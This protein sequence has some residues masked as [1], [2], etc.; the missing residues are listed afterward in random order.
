MKL[1]LLVQ[2]AMII[3][4]TTA[5]L[6][7]FMAAKAMIQLAAAYIDAGT[8]SNYVSMSTEGKS[9]LNFTEGRT[10]VD[11]FNF[12]DGEKADTIQTGDVAISK[13]KVDSGNVIFET[14]NGH[15]EVENAENEVIAFNNDYSGD[16][17][18]QVG[19]QKIIYNSI[20]K[21]Y[22]ASGRN[23]T[24]VVGDI[25]AETAE[26]LLDN[27][28]DVKFYGSI[29][30]IDAS[31]F[32][33]SA[34]LGGND[35]NNVITASAGGSTID[36]GAG[37]DTLHGGA[38]KD[39]FIVGE[40]K[41]LVQY[42]V[43]GT[44]ELADVINT[45]DMEITAMKVSG[46][47]IVATTENGKVT[48]EGAA[49]EV[50]QFQNKYIE[51]DNPLAVQIAEDKI[52]INDTAEYYWATGKNALVAV[53]NYKGDSLVIDLSHTDYNDRSQIGFYGDIK[54]VDASGYD[55]AA[56][57]SGNDKNNILTASDGGSQLWGGGISNDTLVGGDG[58]DVFI[59]GAED[60]NDVI[61][62]ADKNDTINLQSGL[63]SDILNSGNSLFVG[64]DVKITVDDNNTLTVK[65]AKTSG[66]VFAIDG[67][68]YAVNSNG[69]WEL[70]Q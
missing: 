64:N 34:N 57:I 62:N 65:D 30:D 47:N 24:V 28:G 23:A 20:A 4:Q 14:A 37:K 31:E 15:I 63:I 22:F 25:D 58:A 12:A 19:D 1:Y 27:S 39:V 5:N 46:A 55:K 51:G 67:Q 32:N 48:V 2:M 50:V 45:G 26:V 9:T 10:T 60:G 66:A 13:V 54:E 43:A 17:N 7:S 21:N 33:G 70:K 42:F 53:E 59:Y 29:K 3:L 41:D 16:T 52:S 40:D 69:E 8:G 18:L 49:D 61:Q 36:G 35:K 6:Y 56:T 68:N 44:S 38:G 11:N